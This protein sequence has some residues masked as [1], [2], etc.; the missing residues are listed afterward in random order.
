MKMALG[1]R[2]QFDTGLFMY[3]REVGLQFE[4]CH[5]P[6]RN[7][8][9]WSL[10]LKEEISIENLEAIFINL[11]PFI[12]AYYR[13]TGSHISFMLMDDKEVEHLERGTL[14]PTGIWFERGQELEPDFMKIEAK[15]IS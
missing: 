5:S 9:L 13:E 14:T 15:Q 11:Q 1:I 7:M 4:F 12:T 8:S 2:T 6:N 10:L 3:L